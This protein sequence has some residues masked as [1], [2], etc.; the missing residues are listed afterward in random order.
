MELKCVLARIIRLIGTENHVQLR[1][2]ND[3]PR[4]DCINLKN[5][6]YFKILN[7]F[8]CACVVPLQK[9]W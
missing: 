1:E 4:N 3:Q 5:L 7:T 2:M 8:L 6:E 9:T